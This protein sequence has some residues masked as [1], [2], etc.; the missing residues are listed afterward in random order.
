MSDR[1]SDAKVILP[2]NPLHELPE[3]KNCGT[4]VEVLYCSNCGQ[5]IQEFR[6][7]VHKL[8]MDF[9]GDYF[10]FDSKLIRSLRPLFFE[11]GF[12]TNAFMEGK[13]VPYIPPLR[14]YIFCSVIFFLT[15]T[16]ATS[17]GSVKDDGPIPSAAY[18]L[19]TDDRAPEDMR[20]AL[21][22]YL[23]ENERTAA[24]ET[25]AKGMQQLDYPLS[26]ADKAA[27]LQNYKTWNPAQTWIDGL[28]EQQRDTYDDLAE[29]IVKSLKD[30]EKN[31]RRHYR[32]TKGVI[33]NSKTLF[34]NS[35]QTPI[36]AWFEEKSKER[37]KRFE[38]LTDDEMGAMIFK[39]FMTSTPKAL[40]ILMPFFALLLKL[41]YV[42]QD[43]LYIDHLIFAFHFH[44]FLF[45]FLSIGVIA[46]TLFTSAWT[47]A[48]FVISILTVPAVYLFLAL[49]EVHKQSWW[50]TILKFLIVGVLYV[51]TLMTTLTL[52]TFIV[53]FTV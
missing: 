47:I 39:G 43:P 8:I 33:F 9:L 20:Q 27:I 13:R 40:F 19:V 4:P 45:L 3:C 26:E 15:L 18:H 7:S 28:D 36:D 46:V 35:E 10:T 30:S 44:T 1:K 41:V 24:V 6:V 17:G 21:V 22:D 34:G 16:L 29:E 12:L 52:T 32:D 23:Y 37:N 51:T 48:P 2:D 42:R 49:R 5:S 11:P 14:M 38:G 31:K 50:I 53:L 25:F